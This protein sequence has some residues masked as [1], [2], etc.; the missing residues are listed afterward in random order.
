MSWTDDISGDDGLL[1]LFGFGGVVVLI[2]I[3][4]F[5]YCS[6]KNTVEHGFDAEV[7]SIGTCRDDQCG[8]KVKTPQGVLERETGSRVFVGDILRCGGS[9]CYK[10]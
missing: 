3:C 10:D 1:P 7:L 6:H 9:K 5:A 8:V 4:V 2:I